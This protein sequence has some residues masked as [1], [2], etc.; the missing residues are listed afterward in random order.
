MNPEQT[1]ALERYRRD[2]CAVVPQLV[3]IAA[4]DAVASD[5]AVVV[6]QSLRRLGAAAL[7]SEA[8]PDDADAL[9]TDLQTLLHADVKAYLA[10]LRHAAKLLSLARLAVSAPFEDLTRALAMVSPSLPT[11]P[12]LHVMSERLRVPDGYFGLETHQDWPSIQGGLDTFTAWVPLFDVG[13]A[14]FPLEVIP[15]SHRAGLLP[16]RARANA[17]E[18]DPA[19]YD[20]GAF[21]RLA[22]RRGDVVIFTT[23]T[24]HRTAVQDCQGF[25]LA[26]STRYENAAEPTFV[27]RGYPTAYRRSVERDLMVADFPT[28]AQV[29]Q[30]LGP[31]DSR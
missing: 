15:G 16:G 3:P 31:R 9:H 18:I 27:A 2:G 7:S 8:H 20:A 30:A 4:L 14:Q 13:I 21:T 22:A 23:F 1:A 12:V 10:A 29:A 11:T 26:C 25:R 6:R 24:I 5:I 17:T 19:H 28:P